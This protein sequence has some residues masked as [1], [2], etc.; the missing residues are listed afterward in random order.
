MGKQANES[1]HHQQLI[2]NLC[3]NTFNLIIVD[4]SIVKTNTRYMA[5]NLLVQEIGLLVVILITHFALT[6]EMITS[7]RSLS[8]NFLKIISCCINC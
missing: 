5:E 2:G 4:N 1:K 8:V 7:D 6:K 3:C